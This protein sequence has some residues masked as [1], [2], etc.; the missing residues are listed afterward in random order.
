MTV[1][2]KNFLVFEVGKA[3]M[4]RE[5]AQLLHY[6]STLSNVGIFHPQNSEVLILLTTLVKDGKKP[7]N[8][9]MV[10][11]QLI[12][13]G[14]AH[15]QTDKFIM[16]GYQVFSFLRNKARVGTTTQPYVYQGRAVLDKVHSNVFQLGK[17]HGEDRPSKFV[18][19][20]IDCLDG[21]LAPEK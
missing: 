13:D 16:D 7:Y 20:L 1:S 3:Y 17:T 6:K 10:S 2:A 19:K 14:Q 8:D 21:D 18:F 4:T 9:D 15:H 12:I 11:D 5:I